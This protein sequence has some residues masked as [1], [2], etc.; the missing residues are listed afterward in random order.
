MNQKEFVDFGDVI[1]TEKTRAVVK[2]QDG[3]DRFCTYCL[4]P[5]ARGRVRSRKPEN[6]ISEINKIAK[7]GIKEVVITGIHI[8][9]YGKDFRRRNID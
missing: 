7:E 1:Y 3:C 2:V 4:I 8:A 9:S 6:I 5:Y